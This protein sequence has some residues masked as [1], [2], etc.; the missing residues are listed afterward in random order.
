MGPGSFTINKKPEMLYSQF[1]FDELI[2]E[3]YQKTE[4]EQTS[5]LIKL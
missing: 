3:N 1:N 2:G 4:Q 5:D